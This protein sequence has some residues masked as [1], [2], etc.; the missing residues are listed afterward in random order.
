MPMMTPSKKAS[1]CPSC[2]SE[3]VSLGTNLAFY[4]SPTSLVCHECGHL[5]APEAEEG[6]FGTIGRSLRICPHCGGI[7]EFVELGDDQTPW[8]EEC[9]LSPRRTVYP[10][11]DLGHLWK[12]DSE[13]QIQ[14]E[15][16]APLLLPNTEA[17]EYLRRYCGPHCTLAKECDQRL[18]SLL[19]CIRTDKE[20]QGNLF[21]RRTSDGRL[22]PHRGIAPPPS[23]PKATMICANHG[24]FAEKVYGTINK[25]QTIP[26]GS[27][28]GT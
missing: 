6:G 10:S 5:E 16:N 11:T 17:G 1:R 14:M 12:E 24:W 19:D 4:S 26:E 3:K 7:V 23:K 18:G 27:G 22:S 15:L 2:R 20:A 21:Y 9:G 13:I 25:E 8:C 28:S